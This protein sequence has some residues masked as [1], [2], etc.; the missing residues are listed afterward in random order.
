DDAEYNAVVKA[1][2]RMNGNIAKAAELLGIS[3]PTLYDLISRHG[4]VSKA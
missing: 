2:A 3:R 4:I 1:L